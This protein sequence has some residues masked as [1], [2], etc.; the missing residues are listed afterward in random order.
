[1]HIEIRDG[2]VAVSGGPAAGPDVVVES[3]RQTFLGWARDVERPKG[4]ERWAE[5]GRE[6][7]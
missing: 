6:S 2:P 4:A 1:V 3:D 5:D 7:A